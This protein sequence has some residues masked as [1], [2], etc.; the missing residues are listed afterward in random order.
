[1]FL[2]CAEKL[3]I[4]SRL[5]SYL[6]I[7]SNSYGFINSVLVCSIIIIE[8]VGTFAFSNMSNQIK[9]QKIIDVEIIL[10]LTIINN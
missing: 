8:I 6:F 5:L 3:K 4:N 1:M 7:Y 10:L 9:L 2:I